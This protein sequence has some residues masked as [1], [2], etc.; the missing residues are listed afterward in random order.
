MPIPK[1]GNLKVCDN[2]RG[3]SLLD[4]VGKVVGR[5][6]QD[7]LKLIAENVLPDI[8]RVSIELVENV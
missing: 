1:K 6:I 7:R 8:L 3:V 5:V 4:V 2:W